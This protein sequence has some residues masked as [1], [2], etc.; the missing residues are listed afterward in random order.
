MIPEEKDPLLSEFTRREQE[1][2]AW[3]IFED[4]PRITPTGSMVETKWLDFAEKSGKVLAY[5]ITFVFVLGGALISKGTLIFM[6]SQLS[7]NEKPYCNRDID[8]NRQFSVILPD[9]EKIAWMWI[10]LF[11]YCVPQIGTFL[12]AVRMVLYKSWNRPK[13]GEFLKVF[14][15]E[16]LSAVGNAILVYLVLPKMDAVKAIMLTNGLAFIPSILNFLSKIKGPDISFNMIGDILSIMCQGVGLFLLPIAYY[17]N[18]INM[19]F[20]P[21]AAILISIAWWENYALATTSWLFIKNLTNTNKKFT[22][23]RYFTYTIVSLWK[24]LAFFITMVVITTLKDEFPVQQLFDLFPEAFS[25]HYINV[26]EVPNFLRNGT[27][28]EAIAS[29][30][31]QLIESS[32]LTPVWIFLISMS[33]TYLSYIFGKF[34]CKT[35]LHQFSYA[36]PI[37]LTIP[38]AVSII[39]IMCG[40]YN[41]D[42]CSF[43]STIPL[44]L[45]FNSPEPSEIQ[46]FIQNDY[47]YLWLFWIISQAW[48]TA[49]IW[50]PKCEK[51]AKTERLY[52]RPMYEPFVLDQDLAM[53]RRINDEPIRLKADKNEVGN[54]MLDDDDDEDFIEV[55]TNRTEEYQEDIIPRIYA[56]GTMWHETTDEMME[57]LKSILRMDAD[58]NARRLVKEFGYKIDDYYEMETHVFF[59]DAFLRK[60]NDDPDPQINSWVR[61][62]VQSVDEAATYVHKVQ[63]KVKPPV[64]YTTPYGGRLE[65]TLPGNTKMIAHLKDAKKIRKKKRWS[66]VMY[67]YYLLGYKLMAS[68]LEQHRKVL[69]ATNTYIMALDGDIDFQ[70]KAVHLLI[71]LMKKD[72]TLGAACGRIHP[73]GSGVMYWYQMFEYA[74]GHWLQKATEHVIGCVLCSPGCFSL[75]RGEALMDDNVM[76]RYATKSSEAL[77]YVQFDQGEDRWLC[78]LLLQRGYRVEYSA[79][80][81][82]YTHCPEGFNE[83][84][85]QRRRWMPS[86]TANILDLL[87]TAGQTIKAN[88]NISKLYILYQGALMVGTILGPG[89]IFLMLVGAFVAAFQMSQWQSMLWNLVPLI[90]LVVTCSLVSNDKVQLF[91]AAILSGVYSL[92]MMAVLVGILLQITSDGILAPSSL[93]FF[94]VAGEM[95]FTALMHPKELNCLKFG[96]VY[97]VTVPCMYMILVIY[98]VFNMNNVS[99]GTREVTV[100]PTQSPQDAKNPKKPEP[101]TTSNK[102]LRFLGAGEETA[103]GMELSFGNLFRCLCCTLAQNTPL[104]MILERLDKMEER[105][106]IQDIEECKEEEIEEENSEDQSIYSMDISR[107]DFTEEISGCTWLEDESIQRGEV[108]FLT[109]KEE[110]FWE[111]ILDEYLH[112]IDDTADKKRIAADLKNLRDKM[113]L[114]FFMI[115]AIFVLVIFL[116]TLKKDL[117]HVP[118]PFGV[119]SNFTYME[120]ANEIR[121]MKEYLQLEPIGIVFLAAY[122][123]LLVVQFVAMLIH[124][125]QTFS[126]IISNTSLNIFETQVKHV[127]AEENLSM[128]PV[129]FV[130]KIQ[131]QNEEDNEEIN[132]PPGRRPTV[133]HLLNRRKGNLVL[134]L[135]ERFLNNLDRIEDLPGLPKNTLADLQKRRV[136][137]FRKS[138]IPTSRVTF[139]NFGE[140]VHNFDPSPKNRK[141][142][143]KRGSSISPGSRTDSNVN[144]PRKSTIS[145]PSQ[146]FFGDRFNDEMFGRPS[147]TARPSSIETFNR[148]DGSMTFDNNA[149]ELGEDIDV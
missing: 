6:T 106:N 79:A 30:S 126:Q 63:V 137:I 136:T 45:F 7:G 122:A 109:S 99:W 70:P 72:V 21:V 129:E 138:N 113:V 47:P 3:N 50:V 12:R 119:K 62:L 1:K 75:F 127:D 96:V 55:E 146:V 48:I 71:D 44:Y 66:Q 78:T 42:P 76:R 97:Y 74:I 34:A 13:L 114:A 24:C 120:S 135:E 73:L 27:L 60:H 20:I 77:H 84:F 46:D 144:T 110:A 40:K 37:N 125:L 51:M 31:Y 9:E 59:D 95:I 26:T 32:H 52:V 140:E 15:S 117:I 89:T 112:P 83:F 41:T 100:V 94:C 36:V 107:E 8:K 93:F 35:H 103:G 14:I 98:S 61:D 111:G 148:P 116:L 130:K 149:F 65:W 56:C 86:T 142:A 133:R 69:R 2:K 81:D 88:N 28:G 64:K 57:F 85:N 10:L 4:P 22:L 54:A 80:S 87:M 141:S 132:L 124:R 5:F 128:D 131:E 92:V 91:V 121:I 90:I 101:Q 108:N 23:E 17:D 19:W 68:D 145:N 143:M 104:N 58:Q 38:V 134:N 139:A 16:T 49:H 123:I 43:Y 118:W 67:M 82:A 39:I 25:P 147:T 105:L 53:N 29:G 33:F 102:I 115:N 18:D 11:T